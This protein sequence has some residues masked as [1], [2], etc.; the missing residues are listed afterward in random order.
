MSTSALTRRLLFVERIINPAK[1]ESFEARICIANTDESSEDAIS[2]HRL[3]YGR[4]PVVVIQA[5]KLVP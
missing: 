1:R 4:T 2:R 3:E 5:K